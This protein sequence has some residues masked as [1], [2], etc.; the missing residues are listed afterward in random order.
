MTGL[1]LL[2]AFVGLGIAGWRWGADTRESREWRW[3]CCG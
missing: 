2:G 3:G 1:L